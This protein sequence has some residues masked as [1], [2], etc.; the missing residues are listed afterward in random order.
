MKKHVEK[1]KKTYL[2]PEQCQTHCLGP[3]V[4]KQIETGS[5]EVG[6]RGWGSERVAGGQNA[7]L[8]VG[9]HGWGSECIVWAGKRG[10]GSKHI[11]G[12]WQMGKI[13]QIS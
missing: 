13:G 11:A 8:G 4:L 9:M 10:W 2:G 6:T 7:W 1:K 3:W 5:W 12:G